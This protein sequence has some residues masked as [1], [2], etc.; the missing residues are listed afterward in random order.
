MD[1]RLIFLNRLYIVIRSGR[2]Q[3]D[4]HAADWKW[5]FK[6]VGRLDRKIRSVV[7]LRRYEDLFLRE[8]VDSTLPRKA[9][10]SRYMV[11]RT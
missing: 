9:S 11:V 7:K 10:L 6:R 1:I 5:L 8:D 4:R 2:T 3:E